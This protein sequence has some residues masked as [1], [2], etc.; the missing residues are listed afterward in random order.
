MSLE[1]AMAAFS[2]ARSCFLNSGEIF[3]NGLTR[4]TSRQ[5]SHLVRSPCRH[6]MARPCPDLPVANSDHHPPMAGAR[7]PM[8]RDRSGEPGLPFGCFECVKEQ[9]PAC[10]GRF[11]GSG[12]VGRWPRGIPQGPWRFFRCCP[13][14]EALCSWALCRIAARVAESMKAVSRQAVLVL[15]GQT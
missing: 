11:P 10:T 15:P 8:Y 3:V 14:L 6:L 7:V 2:S 4:A 1:S 13:G 9:L 5:L 12:F